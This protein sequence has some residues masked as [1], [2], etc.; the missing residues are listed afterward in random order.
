MA[1]ADRF[2]AWERDFGVTVT[3]VVSK[4]EGTGWAGAT[5]YVQD[6]AKDEEALARPR[7]SAVLMCGMKG[8][9]EGVKELAADSGLDE[10]MVIANF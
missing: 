1:Y 2:T 8:M 4:P 3:P 5:G 7:N 10:K 9:A 6:V